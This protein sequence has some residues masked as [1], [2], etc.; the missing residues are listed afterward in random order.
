MKKQWLAILLVSMMVLSSFTSL[1]APVFGAEEVPEGVKTQVE[2]LGP[3]EDTASELSEG[4]DPQKKLEGEDSQKNAQEDKQ[5]PKEDEAKDT[6]EDQTE[7]KQEL[8]REE[9]LEAQEEDLTAN[10]AEEET[11]LGNAIYLG[12]EK[13]EDTNSGFSPEIPV[14]TLEKAESLA[15]EHNQIQKIYVQGTVDLEGNHSLQGS[16]ATIYRADGFKGYLFKV[17]AKKTASLENIKIDGRKIPAEKSLI[18]V[19]GTLNIGQETLLQNNHIGTREDKGTSGGAIYVH[20]SGSQLTMTAGQIQ[21]NTATF[22]GGVAVGY[23][24]NFD[25]S[26]GRIQGNQA[27]SGDISSAPNYAAS[28]GGVCIDNRATMTMTGSTLVQGNSSEE[29]GG[30]IAIGSQGASINGNNTFTMTGGRIEGNQ[31]RACGGGIFMQAGYSSYRNRAYISAGAIINNKMLGT[32]KMYHKFGGGGIYV[33][34][35]GPG[36]NFYNG[37]LYLTNAIITENKAEK[38][39]GGYAACPVSLT[40]IYVRDGAAIYGNQASKAQDLF[41]YATMDKEEFKAHVGDPEYDIS[42]RMLG[43]KDYQWMDADGLVPYEKLKGTLSGDKNESLQWKAGQTDNQDIYPLGKVIISGNTSTTSGGGIGSNGSVFIGTE[44]GK[45]EIQVE[46]SWDEKVS[47]EPVTVELRAKLGQADWLLEKAQL[48]KENNYSHTF[49]DLPKQI[50][51]NNIEDLV[52]LKE[53]ASSKYEPE[54]SKIEKIAEDKFVIKIKNNPGKPPVEIDITGSKTWVD[55]DNKAGKRPASIRV[56][57]L[58]DG[59]VIQSRDVSQKDGWSWTFKDLPKEKDGKEIVYSIREDRVP[60]YTTEVNG[61]NLK[62]TY[63]PGKTSFSVTK[64]WEDDNNRAGLRPSQVEIKLY[65]NGKDTGKTL[66]LSEANQWT[67]SFTNLDKELDGKE[68]VYGIK[69]VLV[70]NGYISTIHGDS[71]QGYTVKNTRKPVYP[72][73]PV[74]IDIT[75]SK[76]WVDQDNK[77]GK[78]PA[79]IRVHLLADGKVIQSR[80]VSQKDGWSWT[81]KD[82]PKEKDGKEIVY[83]IREDRVPGYTTEVNGYNLKNTYNP[84]KTS[85]PVTKIWEDNNNRDGLRPSQVEIKLYAN[86]KDTGKTLILSE[87]NQWTG[88][89]TDLDKDLAGEK[90]HYSIEEV[91]VDHYQPSISGDQEQGFLVTNYKKDI[92]NPKTPVEPLS[93]PSIPL[94]NTPKTGV[95]SPVHWL[96]LFGLCLVLLLATKK[97]TSKN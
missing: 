52:Y 35:F 94:T 65:A 15:K 79:S 16:S 36:Y 13:G 85:F 66:I 50:D 70:G 22:G 89:F 90:I 14:K 26:G 20:G 44:D 69:E 75:G 12:G 43:G 97:E 74:E 39:G 84:G 45:K 7:E 64:I 57:L 51:G 77:A 28:G 19:E 25:F 78:R 92:P 55:Q 10:Q 30:G 41:I 38:A 11:A 48:S 4:Q 83:S 29:T 9:A 24:G 56:H 27:I 81:F 46:K 96:G 67:G 21:N 86:G 76:T 1:A 37:E 58:A 34:G 47:P 53:E 88:S 40:K 42:P 17:G 71:S 33:N 32:G 61:Y 54:I 80:D 8:A 93:K 63:N 82:L 5:A 23:G 91:G 62:N 2:E 68:I 18:Y 72:N 73:P 3:E 49:K 95:D 87:A 31:S 59:K 6:S 60:G